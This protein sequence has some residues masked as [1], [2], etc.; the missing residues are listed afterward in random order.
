MDWFSDNYNL[1]TGD[2][3]NYIA[4]QKGGLYMWDI[5][6]LT[7]LSSHIQITSYNEKQAKYT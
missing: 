2:M 1:H 6:A 5:V 4:R 7:R 3:N